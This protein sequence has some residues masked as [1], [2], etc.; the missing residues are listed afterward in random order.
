[1][2]EIDL[3]E[4]SWV[5]AIGSIA[6][7]FAAFLISWRDRHHE[8]SEKIKGEENYHK[9]IVDIATLAIKEARY[10]D[11]TVR[12]DLTYLIHEGINTTSLKNHCNALSTITLESLTKKNAFARLH[13]FRETINGIAFT[14]DQ[15]SE[16]VST[17]GLD[18]MYEE[19]AMDQ[20]IRAEREYR[21][22]MQALK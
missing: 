21:A 18:P 13:K 15:A 2:A 22:L 19:A 8:K 12:G 7:I 3:T 9:S 11:Q 20:A 5:Q 6:A 4:P 16:N 1:M 10:I 14:G 17:E